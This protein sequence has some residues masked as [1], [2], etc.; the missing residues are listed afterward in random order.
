[1]GDSWFTLPS[2]VKQTDPRVSLVRFFLKQDLRPCF[3]Y[4][5]LLSSCRLL[6]IVE[7]YIA[8]PGKI[9]AR[10]T[11]VSPALIYNGLYF[12]FL[13]G[14]RRISRVTIA[15]KCCIVIGW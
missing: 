3:I 10:L 8:I 4:K 15:P 7:Q 5:V 12:H 14:G 11:G 13:P 2:S 1:M 6:S 9:L